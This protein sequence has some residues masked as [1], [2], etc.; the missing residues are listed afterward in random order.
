MIYK[1]AKKLIL[2]S[3]S[4]RRRELLS[5]CG[6]QFEVASAD[7][8]ETVKLAES[9]KDLVLRLAQEKAQKVASKHQGCWVLAADTDVALDNR[10]FG[11]P[12]DFDQ[13]VEILSLLSGAT[14][15]VYG[16]IALLNPENA[17]VKTTLS[18]TSVTFRKL[19]KNEIESY[20]RSKEPYDKAG[21]YAAQGLGAG[22]IYAIQG[23]YT[24]VVGLDLGITL[25]LLQNSGVIS[26]SI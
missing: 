20:A 24:N 15:T 10:I 4:P 3:A 6:I 16:G 8:D 22:F 12:A 7:I 9:P 25:E 5:D 26:D 17:E 14:H 18:V 11:K 13:A 2:A 23:S 21:G 1:T 19:S